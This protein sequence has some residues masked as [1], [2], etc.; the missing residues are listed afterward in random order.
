MNELKFDEALAV[1]VECFVLYPVGE[2]NVGH[3][4]LWFKSVLGVQRCNLF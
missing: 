4:A 2:A 3:L 1:R